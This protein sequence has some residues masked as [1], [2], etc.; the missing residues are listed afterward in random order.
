[1]KSLLFHVIVFLGAALVVVPMSIRLGFG[2]VLGYLLAGVLIGPS[3]MKLVTDVDAILHFS[4]LGIVLMM[5]VIGLEMHVSRLWALR[6]TIFGYGGMQMA[7]CAGLL[8]AIFLAFGSRWQIA[9]TAGLALALSSTAMALSELEQRGQMS[10]LAGE[11][12][13]GIL[14]FQDL[15]AIPLVAL[16]PLLGPIDTG[17]SAA[18]NWIAVGKALAMLV[19]VV[20]VGRVALRHGLRIVSRSGAPEIFTA[21]A[22]LWVIGVALLFRSVHLSASLGAFLAG[23][24]LADSGY[25]QQVER[26][27]APFKGLLLGLFFIAIG[28]SIDFGVLAHDTRR[29]LVVVAAVVGIKAAVLWLLAPRFNVPRRQRAYFALLLSQ[30]GEFAFVVMSSA[31]AVRVV[32]PRASAIVTLAVALSMITTPLLLLPLRRLT[33]AEPAPGTGPAPSAERPDAP[34]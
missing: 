24:L 1:M 15:A 12:A 18:E 10:T 17:G 26:H 23:V 33:A 30:G 8:T 27:I 11:A 9:V 22:L 31:L 25:Q 13:F 20:L 19:A 3:V 14:L 28:M 7:L 21:F 34:G 2:P 29:V 6:R 32:E 4:E 5:F 16:L